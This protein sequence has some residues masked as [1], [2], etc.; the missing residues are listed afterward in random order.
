MSSSPYTPYLIIL[1]F[2]NGYGSD[3]LLDFSKTLFAP[4][5]SSFKSK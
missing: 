4:F 3:S 5:K 1:L 2:L